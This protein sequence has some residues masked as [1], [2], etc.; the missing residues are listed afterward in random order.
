MPGRVQPLGELGR[1]GMATVYVA[2]QQAL[3]RQVAIK[4]VH[5]KRKDDEAW[6]LRLEN[7]AQGM[8][9]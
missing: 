3:N 6:V 5:P 9:D 1:G 7:E 8:E 2:R 4:V